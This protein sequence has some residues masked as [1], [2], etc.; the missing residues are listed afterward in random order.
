[1]S[2]DGVELMASENGYVLD[3]GEDY[4][5]RL[6]ALEDGDLD[7]SFEIQ[8]IPGESEEVL[9][10][11]EAEEVETLLEAD[12]AGEVLLGEEKEIACG[13][14]YSFTPPEDGWYVLYSQYFAEE[15]IYTYF[16]DS[17]R[18]LMQGPQTWGIAGSSWKNT[19]N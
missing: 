10:V 9:V 7:V 16:Y 15:G 11:E 3:A 1:M 13:E 18:N 14:Y 2:E 5:F 6:E 4:Y 12:A 17:T 8:R 19:P